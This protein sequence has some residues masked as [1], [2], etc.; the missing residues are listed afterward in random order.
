MPGTLTTLIP[1]LHRRM[2]TFD[3]EDLH[4]KASG[5]YVFI[6]VG[7]PIIVV[8]RYECL[9]SRVKRTIELFSRR[10]SQ[11]IGTRCNLSPNDID[12]T[13]QI[14]HVIREGQWKTDMA[15]SVLNA[16]EF[17]LFLSQVF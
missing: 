12:V 15:H 4:E 13:A 2:S 14:V 5:V 8:G 17:G 6:V 9:L 1:K 11:G 10:P 7:L 16:V 3:K